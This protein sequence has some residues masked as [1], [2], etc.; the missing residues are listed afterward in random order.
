MSATCTVCEKV[1][2][3][4]FCPDGACKSCHVDLSF[5]DC[6]DKTW[7]ARL[8]LRQGVRSRQDILKIYPDARI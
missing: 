1:V 6:S 4:P 2:D 3:G 5:E 7:N 8:L